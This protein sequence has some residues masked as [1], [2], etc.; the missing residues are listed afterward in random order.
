MEWKY[1]IDIVNQDVFSEI[2]KKY[3][4]TISDELRKL[5]LIANAA[6]PSKYNFLLGTDEK[7]LG[8]ILSFNEGET[9]TD[10]VYTALATIED[11]SLVPFAID[12]FGNYVCC[13]ACD[14]KVFFWN[15]ETSKVVST[16]KGLS[17]FI[18]SL[19]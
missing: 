8:A 1:K 11:K 4:I 18:E 10:T 6:T 7:V 12:P 5:I 9:D 14:N 16:G 17:E 2:E 13:S 15:H 3:S 19:Y